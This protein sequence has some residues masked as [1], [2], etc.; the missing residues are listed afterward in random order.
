MI[1]ARNARVAGFTFL[2]YIAV[3]IGGVITCNLATSGSTTADRLTSVAAHPVSVTLSF[4]CLLLTILCALI[5]GI[6]LFAL[7]R[8]QD[9]DLARF[10][11]SCRFL[12]AAINAFPAIALLALIS[13]ATGNETASA[14]AS[15]RDAIASLLLK[16]QGWSTPTSATMFAI[17][18]AIYCALFLRGRL[19]PAWLMRLGLIASILLIVV[20]PLE[21]ARVVGGLIAAIVWLPMLAFE[22]PFGIWLLVTGAESRAREMS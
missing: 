14:E 7:T 15:T 6:T 16:V 19:A 21:A 11:M 12:E 9:L 17:G 1:R 4:I 5:L 8:Q 18:S 10:A 22:A 2:F 3:G 13:L 20:E